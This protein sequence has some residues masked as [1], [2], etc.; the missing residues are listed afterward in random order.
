MGFGTA[1]N[2]AGV[3]GLCLAGYTFVS[4]R[5]VGR[6][7]NIEVRIESRERRSAHGVV[8]LVLENHGR[9]EATDVRVTLLAKDGTER[10]G[11][12]YR[13]TDA[14]AVLWPGQR[15]NDPLIWYAGDDLAAATISWRDGRRKRQTR[16]V[17]L[18]YEY[19]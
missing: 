5:L 10:P 19:C 7:A 18:S 14:L 12:L 11:K 1:A 17:W 3:A 6:H 13:L 4:D 9:H 8:Q 15:F 16:D 2:V